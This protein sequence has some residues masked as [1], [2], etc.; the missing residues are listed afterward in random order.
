MFSTFC[1][2]IWG[3]TGALLITSSRCRPLLLQWHNGTWSDYLNYQPLLYY[4]ITVWMEPGNSGASSSWKARYFSWELVKTKKQSYKR[5]TVVQY[6][7]VKFAI[8]PWQ[9]MICV[10]SQLLS[11]APRWP[12]I[13]VTAGLKLQESSQLLDRT[14][15]HYKLPCCYSSSV[16]KQWFTHQKSKISIWCCV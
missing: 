6:S 7:K 10:C 8:S 5:V 16:S 1:F 2:T 14:E 4:S 15:P 13:S 9:V 3:S 11:A 12:E